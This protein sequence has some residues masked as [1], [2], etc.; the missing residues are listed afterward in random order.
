MLFLVVNRQDC[1]H[2]L[3]IG[4]FN[5]KTKTCAFPFR[6]NGSGNKGNTNNVVVRTLQFFYGIM[7]FEKHFT[8]KL[9][10]VMEKYTTLCP[11]KILYKK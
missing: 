9:T 10:A 11:S 7:Q 4:S 3:N 5:I 8:P 2:L 6:G 1:L